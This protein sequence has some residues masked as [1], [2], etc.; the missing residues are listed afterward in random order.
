VGI[1]PNDDHAQPLRPT[2]VENRGRHADLKLG[3]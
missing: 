2:A 1:D 3:W